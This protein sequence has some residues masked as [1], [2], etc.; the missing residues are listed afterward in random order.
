MSER[1][2]ETPTT[3][4]TNAAIK[5][6]RHKMLIQIAEGMNHPTL[7]LNDFNEMLVVAGLPVIVPSEVDV[8]ELKVIKI[9]KEEEE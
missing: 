6:G 7:S 1:F 2:F 5:L 9:N 4:V 8:P 3:N